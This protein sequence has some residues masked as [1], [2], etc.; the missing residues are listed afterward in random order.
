MNMMRNYWVDLFVYLICF[1][2]ALYG[3]SALD[4][5]KFLKP[6]KSGQSWMLWLMCAMGLAYLVGN[7]LLAIKR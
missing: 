5:K 6:S 7:F 1:A 4:F 2:F 3:M